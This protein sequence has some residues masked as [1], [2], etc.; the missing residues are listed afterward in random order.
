MRPPGCSTMLD[1]PETIPVVG[2]YSFDKGVQPLL[3]TGCVDLLFCCV[4]LHRRSQLAYLGK[5]SD[6]REV[7]PVQPVQAPL[8]VLG[9]GYRETSLLAGVAQLR[10][11]K[12]EPAGSHPL[13]Q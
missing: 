4:D 11:L 3:L 5:G 13:H 1:L 2:T 10:V 8:V 6:R 9:L 7:A 12:L